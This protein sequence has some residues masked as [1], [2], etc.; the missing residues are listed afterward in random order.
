MTKP[1]VPT[2]GA[3]ITGP[4]LA[5]RLPHNGYW[6]TVVEHARQLRSAGS[7]T[8]VKAPAIPVAERTGILPQ[9]REFATRNRTPTLPGPGGRRILQLPLTP[10]KAPTAEVTRADLPEVLHRPAQ[11]E[12]EA[13]AEFVSDDTDTAP[14]QDEDG[15]DVTF[16]RS[17]PRRFDSA[18]GA[19]GTHSA[20]RRLLSG[21]EQQFTSGPGP[22]GATVPPEPD[23][24]E[25]PSEKTIPTAP[26]RIL[27]LHPSRTTPLA[28]FTFRTAQPAPHDR[29]NLTPHR[30][31]MAG[32]YAGMQWRAPELVTAL[33]DH[34]TP[35]FNP[36]TTLR[37]PSRSRGQAL[38]PRDTAATAP[39]GDKSSTAT[40]G[41]YTLTEEPAAQPSDPTHALTAHES[42]HPHEAGPRQRHITL[43]P[44]LIAPHTPAR[45]GL[46]M[47][48]TVG[49]TAGRTH[50]IATRETANRQTGPA[51]AAHR[52]ERMP[53][54]APS[55][56]G[57]AM[58]DAPG[59]RDRSS[60]MRQIACR[61]PHR[62]SRRS[63]RQWALPVTLPPPR[64]TRRRSAGRT[65][66][67]E[68][69]TAPPGH[70]SQACVPRCG[71]AGTTAPR[72]GTRC[73]V[74]E[75]AMAVLK[76]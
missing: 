41:A 74:G 73:L 8:V 32:A 50:R 49:R 20:V 46:A 10:D 3:G 55:R 48:N 71:N 9:L 37:I 30:Q 43:P 44:R 34:P 31:T 11:T 64:A 59:R 27:L 38:P 22:H 40:A 53:A 19:D 23:T 29:K 65:R 13:E 76:V 36:L 35:H 12:T 16:R 47:R 33:P 15:E 60:P 61:R 66:R 21:P 14:D 1:E 54:A 67:L 5:Y 45:P 24:V 62:R 28:I 42:H 56:T 68:A 18:V 4:A 58:S 69:P 52:S 63:P 6:P 7:A 17:A 39:P 25:D 26:N 51:P 75:Q 70:P 2:V 57:A 72:A